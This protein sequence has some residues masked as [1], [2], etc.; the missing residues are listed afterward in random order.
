MFLLTDIK[1]YYTVTISNRSYKFT[2]IFL[3]NCILLYFS[4]S[5]VILFGMKADINFYKFLNTQIIVMLLLTLTTGTGF[6]YMGLLYDTLL[7]STLWYILMFFLSFVGYKLHREF[8]DSDLTLYEENSWHTRARGFLFLYFSLWTVIFLVNVSSNSIELHYIAIATQLGTSVVSATLLVSEKKL[9]RIILISLMTPLFIYFLLIDDFYSYLLAVFTVV[10]LGVLMYASTNTYNYLVKNRYQAYNDYLTKLGN[11]RYFIDLLEDS[12]KSQNKKNDFKYLLLIDLD[13]FKNI[14]DSLGHDI[15]DKL[16][17]EVSNRM[18]AHALKYDNTIAR[19]GGD[20]FCVLSNS[21]KTKEEA[22][23]KAEDFSQ[24]LLKDIKE[25]YD[26]EE[27]HLY[28][29]ASI[30]L[31]IMNNSKLEVNVFLKEA[32]IAMYE[33]KSQ[34]RDGVIIFNEEL[35]KKVELK[36]EIERHLHFALEK[37]EISLMFQPQ[38]NAQKE[39]V[40]CEVLARWDNDIL[41]EI[42]PEVF[43]PISEQTGFIIELGHFIIEESFKT[44]GDWDERG[45][46]VKQLSINISMRQLFHSSFIHDVEKLCSKYLNKKLSSKIVFEMTETS[47]AED[48]NRLISSMNILKDLGIRF[49]MDDFGTGYS[50]LS[51]LRQLPIDELK[52]D[53]SF[54]I[55]LDETKDGRDMVKTILNIAK[56]LNLT[57]VAEGIEEVA[58][59]E[60]LIEEKCDILQGYYFSKPISKDDFEVYIC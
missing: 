41:G 21:F 25:Y 5:D 16:L 14:N 15:G 36:L 24:Q 30:G 45:I 34:G 55:G 9:S 39:I 23:E 12:I 19:L 33:A 17:V 58:Q 50:S 3:L 48:I 51:Y 43:I 60:F 54:I 32:D 13:H 49:S 18:S 27:H 52:I 42:G 28:I 4:D 2:L 7:P 22:L 38:L 40:G 37:N 8:S 1:Y 35:S 10:L 47:V 53:K 59:K 31:S 44:L 57:I 29:S 20:E 46:N 6:I 26:I 56:N 11:R